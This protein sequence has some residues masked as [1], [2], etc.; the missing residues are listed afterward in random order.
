MIRMG[1]RWG[2]LSSEPGGARVTDRTGPAV[3]GTA[4][5]RP[6]IG[7]CAVSLWG[8]ALQKAGLMGLR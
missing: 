7:F 4:T 1:H 2:T 6:G 8:H 3:P 5:R